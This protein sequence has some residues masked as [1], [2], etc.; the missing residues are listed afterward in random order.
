MNKKVL[1]TGGSGFIGSQLVERLQNNGDDVETFDIVDGYDLRNLDEAFSKVNGKDIVFHLAAVADLNWARIHPIATMEINVK[2]TWCM[3]YA[4]KQFGVKLYYA[5]TCCIYGQQKVHPVD[6][7]VA[8]NPTEVY[9]CSKLAGENVIKGFH[10]SYGLEYNMM[11]FATIYGEGTRPALGTHIFMGQALRGEP[12][13][14]HGDGKQTRTLTYIQDLIDGIM[15]LYRSGE[16]NDA[17]NLSTTE[18]VS[19]LQMA[20]DIK[21]LT[22]SKSEI[23]FIPQRIGQT[24]KESINANKMLNEVGW[25]AETKWEDGINKMYRWFKETNQVENLYKM[26]K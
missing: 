9:A 12:L 4:C 24:F 20:E 26:P 8:P 2:G 3:A 18:E 16:I 6:E 10:C 22:N 11:R 13:T 17:W 5:S 19:A 15:A 1:V 21:R 7:T 14:I 23:A 25:K